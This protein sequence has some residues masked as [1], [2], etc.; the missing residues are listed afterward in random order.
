MSV[1]SGWHQLLASEGPVQPGKHSVCPV[2]QSTVE[3]MVKER[4]ADKVKEK[5]FGRAE[6]VLINI[7][8]STQFK[9]IIQDS[10]VGSPDQHLRC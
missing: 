3:D 8:T 2:K 10:C 5:T 9:T 7:Q 6:K 1:V 4:N